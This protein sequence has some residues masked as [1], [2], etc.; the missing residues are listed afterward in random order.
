M[1]PARAGPVAG[2]PRTV[3]VAGMDGPGARRGRMRVGPSGVARRAGGRVGIA[4]RR[5]GVPVPVPGFVPIDN[6][7]SANPQS[8]PTSEYAKP[9]SD[10]ALDGPFLFAV[11][12]LCL[13]L[14]RHGRR[15]GRGRPVRAVELK[16]LQPER[17][18]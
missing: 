9:A 6:G 13:S 12:F 18:G 17:G 5:R 16:D 4:P 7:P 10:D 1:D 15:G 3:A 11:L 8:A 14:R 2:P